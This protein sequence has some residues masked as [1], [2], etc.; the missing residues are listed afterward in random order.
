VSAEVLFADAFLIAVCKPAGLLTV[1]GRNLGE[2]SLWRLLEHRKGHKL[3]AVHRLDRETSGVVLFARSAAAHRS[4]SQAFERRL[5]EKIYL[6]RVHPAPA[7]SPATLRST[8]VAARRGFMRTARVGESGQEAVTDLR[9]LGLS[10]SGDAIVELR[11]RTGRT[12][13]LR[14]QLAEAGSPIVGEPHYRELGGA[15]PLPAERLWL[16][17]LSLEFDHPTTYQRLKI[18]A[19]PPA[20]LVTP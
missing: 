15:A 8:I 5:V 1:P 9:V 13:Q 3:F 19:P 10:S 7:V 4:L 18:E 11:P 17:A 6:A 14:L 20:E 16:H 12:H 2:A